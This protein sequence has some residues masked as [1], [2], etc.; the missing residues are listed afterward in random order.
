MRPCQTLL[1]L[2]FLG[3]TF[4]VLAAPPSFTE[5]TAAAGLAGHNHTPTYT[6]SYPAGGAVGDFDN[7]GFQDIFLPGGG[8]QPDKLFMNNGD[9]TFSNQAQAWGV[10]ATHQSTG[11]A[12][13]DFNR[14][15]WLDL[16]VSSYTSNRLYRNEGGTGFVNVANSAGVSAPAPFGGAFGDFDL[17]GDLDLAVVTF[18]SAAANLFTTQLAGLHLW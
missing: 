5:V 11:A 9:G 12:V 4:P 16:F 3:L 7:D 2:L 8:G 14:D 17:D 1:A 10:A 6:H 15:G 13:G 18:T